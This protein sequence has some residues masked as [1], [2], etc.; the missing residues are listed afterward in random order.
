MRIWKE[1]NSV[2][3]IGYLKN[4]NFFFRFEL[5]SPAILSG[6]KVLE[7]EGLYIVC[8]VGDASCL[9]KIR[10]VLENEDTERNKL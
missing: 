2:N 7:G 3:R 10:S 1:N 9:G 4:Y 8:V 6:T 5:P